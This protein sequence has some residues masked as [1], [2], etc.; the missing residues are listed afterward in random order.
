M[1]NKKVL[2]LS[3]LFIIS[4]LIMSCEK[5]KYHSEFEKRVYGLA[6]TSK[7]VNLNAFVADMQRGIFIC[8][9][10]EAVRKNGERFSQL[11]GGTWVDPMMFSSDGTGKIYFDLGLSSGT[12]FCYYNTIEWEVSVSKN[13]IELY[14][15]FIDIE[16]RYEH[17]ASRTKLELLYYK[18]GHFVMKGAQPYCYSG[19]FVDYTL[20]EG[21]I[22]FDQATLDEFAKYVPYEEIKDDLAK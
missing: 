16:N 19:P 7:K 18:D 14:D 21:W 6:K 22:R 3:A 11:D 20:I 13:T 17:M 8:T 4:G 2:M 9:E 1:K 12:S 15:P 10:Y 5:D